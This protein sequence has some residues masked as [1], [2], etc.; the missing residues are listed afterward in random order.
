MIRRTLTQVE[1]L[2]EEEEELICYI[3]KM[4][5]HFLEVKIVSKKYNVHKHKGCNGSRICVVCK[6]PM[7]PGEAVYLG[8]MVGRH[9]DCYPGSRR[10][11][12]SFAHHLDER[13]LKVM[14]L[15]KPEERQSKQPLKKRAIHEKANTVRKMLRPIKR[16]PR[17]VGGSG[18]GKVKSLPRVRLVRKTNPTR[19]SLL[20]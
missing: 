4:P 18:K 3:C 13:E 14:K 9:E 15:A 12:K 20:R 10:W 17:R 2:E 11:M 19:K 6:K 7:I 1:V 5:I 8:D 16:I